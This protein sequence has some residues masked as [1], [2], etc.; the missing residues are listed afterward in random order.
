MGRGRPRKLREQKLL[1]GTL[2]PCRDKPTVNGELISE[3]PQSSVPMSD[4]AFEY[5]NGIGLQLINLGVLNQ[6]DLTDLE[7][8]AYEYGTFWLHENK[9]QR[10]EKELENINK[11][12]DIAFNKGDDSG[13][14]N[15]MA[16]HKRIFDEY[17]VSIRQ[18]NTSL[19]K[20]SK[21]SA[22]FGLNPVDRQKLSIAP[23]QVEK[24]PFADE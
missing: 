6:T 7:L 8:L 22:R 21:M 3:L 17:K 20:A 4:I 1:S 5:Y 23:P 16:K 10:L 2:Q 11:E 9:Q 18:R 15:L 14:R 19:E 24:D 12:I 13:G